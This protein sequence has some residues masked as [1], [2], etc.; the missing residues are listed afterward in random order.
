VRRGENGATLL[1]PLVASSGYRL[2]L[3]VDA[4][5]EARIDI[6]VNGQDAGHCEPASGSPCDLTLAPGL[7]R[8]G[9][10][11]LSLFAAASPGSGAV[12]LTFS[13]ARIQR[14]DAYNGPGR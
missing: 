2:Q 1:L 11:S 9:V 13:R 12:V 14:L 3:E 8:D 7:L 4:K 5:P 6:R 10:N